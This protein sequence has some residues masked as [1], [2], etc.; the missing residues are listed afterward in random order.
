MT[1]AGN[2]RSVCALTGRAKASTTDL[3]RWHNRYGR[4]GCDGDVPTGIGF[5][6]LDGASERLCRV[7]P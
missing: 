5:L 3:L 1:Y 6:P 2:R 4:L 7:K